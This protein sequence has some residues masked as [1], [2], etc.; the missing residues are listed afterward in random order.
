MELITPNSP[1]IKKMKVDAKS[2]MFIR[3]SRP[4]SVHFSRT[5]ADNFK[6]K[7]FD[8]VQFVKEGKEVWARIVNEDGFIVTIDGKG[9]ARICDT[10]LTRWIIDTFKKKPPF[11]LKVVITN[12]VLYINSEAK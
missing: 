9:N 12:G 7:R 4:D 8:K 3:I 1:V 11:R 6:L 10:A 5:A 2:G